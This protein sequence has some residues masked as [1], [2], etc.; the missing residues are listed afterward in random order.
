MSFPRVLAAALLG[1]SAPVLLAQNELSAFSSTGRAAATTFVTDYQSVGINP[2]NLGWKWA[3]EG[4]SLA[5][6]LAEGSYSVHSDALTRSDL[7]DRVL[8]ADFR[9]T[10]AEKEEAG[11]VFANAGVIAQVDV[12]SIG[13]SFY[14]E[15][16]GGFAF[17][18]RD[19]AQFST[20]FGARMAQIAFE[21]YRSDYFDLLVL[22][23]GDTVVNYANM[24]ADSL[25]MVVL[26]V[27]TEPQLLGRVLDGT[28]IGATWYR[29]YNFSY[30]RHLVRNDGFELHAGVG[31]KYLVGIGIIDVR[32][33]NGSISGFSSLSDVFGID[34][35][36]LE[37]RPG[38]RLT[39]SDLFFPQAAGRGFGVD[40]GLSALIDGQWKIGA[41]LTNLG[42]ITWD[43]Q[44]YTV[45]N[46]SL[47]DLASAGLDNYALVDNLADFVTDAGILTWEQGRARKV[48]LAST[49]RIGVGRQFGRWAEVGADLVLPLNEEPGSLQS[50]LF[51]VGGDVRPVSW[52]Q[53]SAGL[54]TGGGYDTKVPV[55]ITFIAGNG[56]WE[57]GIASRDVIT[58]FSEK[59]PTVSLSIGFLRFR[60]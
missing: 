42:S 4:K 60:F 27:A 24:S 36:R 35:E 20:R 44:V 28:R 39:T 22:A 55:G 32:A 53:L 37:R 52:L 25:A 3:H 18:V 51:G 57:A 48:P 49:A 16:V 59:N 1:T 45:S 2:A 43:G 17:Q 13:A 26:G 34:H 41:A 58:Y 29:E 9:F 11:R 10:Q 23:T 30:G 5:F 7:R 14:H 50:A 40:L 8:S 31:L 12:M 15:Q 46:G 33:E 19:R 54:M 6:G 56:T 47:V 38:A 21:G